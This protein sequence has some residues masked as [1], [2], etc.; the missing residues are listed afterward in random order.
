M[1]TINLMTLNLVTSLCVYIIL[2]NFYYYLNYYF[3]QYY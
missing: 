1:N 3:D 2:T